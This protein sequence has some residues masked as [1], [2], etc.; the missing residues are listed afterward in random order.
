MYSNPPLAGARLVSTVLNT[1]ELHQ[2]WYFDCI[3]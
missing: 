2:E 3:L 1:P